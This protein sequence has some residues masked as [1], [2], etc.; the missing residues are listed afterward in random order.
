M[1]RSVTAWVPQDSQSDKHR[2]MVFFS[3]EHTSVYNLFYF[4]ILSLMQRFKLHKVQSSVTSS[5]LPLEN[6]W[7]ITHWNLHQTTSRDEENYN[8]CMDWIQSR[9]LI[10][11]SPWD[12]EQLCL[13]QQSHSDSGRKWPFWGVR[14]TDE[15]MLKC[16]K[17][18]HR[19]LCGSSFCSSTKTKMRDLVLK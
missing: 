2:L 18:I 6:R 9:I 7:S 11:S 17:S 8:V 13:V 12:E 3:N 5:A 16:H 1:L 4:F 10:Y 19:H 14:V 15:F